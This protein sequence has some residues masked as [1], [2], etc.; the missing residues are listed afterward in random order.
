MNNLWGVCLSLLYIALVMGAAALLAKRG[1]LKAEG[2]RKFIHILLS[3]WW[4]IALAVY[5]NPWWAAA[6]PALFVAVNALSWRFGI[7]KSMERDGSAADL[8]TV[9]YAVTLLVLSFL[10]FSLPSWKFA[11]TIGVLSMGY[12]DGLAAVA[13]KHFEKTRFPHSEKTLAG[14]LALF[15]AVFAVALM[16][17]WYAHA[18]HPLSLSLILAAAAAAIELVTPWGLDNLTLPIGLTLL[19]PLLQSSPAAKDI[20][21][22]AALSLLMIMPAWG[23]RLLTL[24]AALLAVLTGT[25][26]YFAGG[27]PMFGALGA[28][29]LS[30]SLIGLVG[31]DSK[32]PVAESVHQRHG[33]RKLVQV[34]A[35]GGLPLLFALLYRLTRT[36]PFALAFT[37]NLAAAN[38]DTWASELG[39]LSKTP[40]RSLLTGKPVQRGVSGG[41]TLLGLLGSALGALVVTLAGLFH[42]PA[43]GMAL[44]QAAWAGIVFLGGVAGSLIDSLLGDSVQAKYL[45]PHSGALTEQ[46]IIG[47]VNTQLINGMRCINNDAVNFISAAVVSLLM[48]FVVGQ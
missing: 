40:P 37:V 32:R 29:F 3:N 19:L 22:G 24:P 7:F 2:G 21:L 36:E 45:H 41:F 9:W 16:V 38:A 48:L 6:V 28:F 11:A 34:L 35:N 12:G 15:A 1:A 31:R 25:G 18:A 10:A 23:L 8:G 44:S 4:L 17:S 30:S 27:F 33:A 5:D 13:G 14:S 43:F 47:G 42:Q 20:L 46:P 39:M 26:I